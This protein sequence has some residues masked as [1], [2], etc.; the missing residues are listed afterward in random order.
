MPGRGYVRQRTD[1]VT[2][3]ADNEFNPAI[4]AYRYMH[5]RR[6]RPAAVDP[7]AIATRK[8]SP[9][10]IQEFWVNMLVVAVLAVCCVAY[11]R[12]VSATR[13]EAADAVAQRTE[14]KSWEN[15]GGNLAPSASTTPMTPVQ[16]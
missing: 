2:A 13:R 8:E 5:R 9:M 10:D 4:R 14:I 7:I 1:A 11:L 16:N 3:S 6:D 15:E 12:H